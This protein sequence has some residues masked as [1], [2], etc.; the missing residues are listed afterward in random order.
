M[1]TNKKKR[2]CKTLDVDMEKNQLG[3]ESNNISVVFCEY[4]WW[5]TII[6]W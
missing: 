5:Q 6:V 1:K 2:A 3:D 4:I